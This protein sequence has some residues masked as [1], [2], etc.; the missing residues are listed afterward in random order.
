MKEGFAPITVDRVQAAYEKSELRP[1]RKVFTR[2]DED[3]T[4]CGCGISAL[5]I[6]EGHATFKEVCHKAIHGGFDQLAKEKL[7]LNFDETGYFMSGFD[8]GEPTITS[9]N[10]NNE[11]WMIGRQCAAALVK[12]SVE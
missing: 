6:G 10:W 2:A 5:L 8:S 4:K 1:V 9:R 12:E 3:G 7:G 11:M